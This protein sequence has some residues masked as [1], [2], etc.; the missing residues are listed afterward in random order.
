MVVE[1]VMESLVRVETRLSMA[2]EGGWV[3]SLRRRTHRL[4][5]SFT[6]GM[7]DVAAFSPI[8]WEDAFFFV[9][10]DFPKS[11]QSFCRPRTS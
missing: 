8:F 11:P 5:A 1:V 4:T 6:A 10:V 2:G 9:V 7:A 3:F